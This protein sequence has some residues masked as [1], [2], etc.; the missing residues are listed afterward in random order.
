MK[1]MIG[2]A[3]RVGRIDRNPYDK[4]GTGEFK[5]GKRENLEYLTD[6]EMQAIVSLRPMAGSPMCVARDLFVFQLYTGMS[7]SDTQR[8]DIRQYKKVDGVWTSNQERVKTGVAYV[9][10]LFPPV[11][12]VLE[13]Y[14]MQAPKI[15]N[16]DYN[17]ALKAIQMATGITTR[18]HSHLARHSFATWMLRNGVAMESLAKMMGH[19]TTRETQK[20][21]KV[22]AQ[23]V[24]ED[25]GRVA[26]LFDNDNKP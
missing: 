17:H 26:R 12:E 15:G 19:T 18:L 23:M 9:S 5:T 16:A 10:V 4:I 13:R 20:Y 14:G 7:Y 2:R 21:A 22:T 24:H 25:F 3:M 11:V 8:F 1:Y 6:E